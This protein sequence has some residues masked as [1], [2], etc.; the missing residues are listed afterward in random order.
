M[1]RITLYTALFTLIGMLLSCE[2]DFDVTAERKDVT[3]VYGLL[4]QQ[5]TFSY[6]KVN[7]AFLG[8]GDALLMAAN[9]DSSYYPFEDIEVWLEEYSDGNFTGL[10][11]PFDTI[12]IHDKEAGVFYYPDQVLYYAH[13]LGKLKQANTYRVIVTNTKS[14]KIVYAETPLV[15]AFSIERPLWNPNNP[16]T[17][18]N[19]T[20]PYSAN[21]Y[22]AANGKRYEMVVRFNYYETEFGSGDTAFKYLDWKFPVKKAETLS[23]GRLMEIKYDGA[24]FLGMI[25]NN[26]PADPDMKRGIGMIDF[27]IT[28][29]ADEL[30]TYIEV[31]EPSSSLITER[32]E[33]S[34]IENGIGIFS[35]RYQKKQ[36]YFLNVQT[37]T[38][39]QD[40]DLGF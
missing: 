34:N 19:G 9:P 5:D 21:W 29:G 10:A 33:Y 40:M 15:S 11:I 36:S 25:R 12:T 6:I 16:V 31:N 28:V 14:G 17:G 20:V 30:N 22:T 13:T 4:N 8:E 7:K 23:G 18:F 38:L 1:K 35:A 37:T 3:V 24:G 32:P 27:I 2:T 39:I 26:I